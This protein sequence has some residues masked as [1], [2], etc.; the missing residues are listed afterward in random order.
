M[1]R[2]WGK[3]ARLEAESWE[4]QWSGLPTEV[5]WHRAGSW[6]CEQPSQGIRMGPVGISSTLNQL[7]CGGEG[8]KGK[9]QNPHIPQAWGQ[10]RGV[11]PVSQV[12]RHHQRAS[13]FFRDLGPNTYINQRRSLWFSTAHNDLLDPYW[14]KAPGLADTSFLYSSVRYWHSSRTRYKKLLPVSLL[15]TGFSWHVF[16]LSSNLSEVMETRQVT[17]GIIS[18]LLPSPFKQA[19]FDVND[20]IKS[21]LILRIPWAYPLPARESQSTDWTEPDTL[22]VLNARILG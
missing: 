4:A 7:V 5:C 20:M 17:R 22:W 19:A 1:I 8:G 11:V 6:L 9:R 21:K 10:G 12:P 18:S 2:A 15:F 13:S 3:G 16:L 14:T